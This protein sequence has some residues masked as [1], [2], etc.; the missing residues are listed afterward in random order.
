MRSYPVRHL[1]TE[2]KGAMSSEQESSEQ[3][4]GHRLR[5]EIN[6]LATH[7]RSLAQDNMRLRKD[8]ETLKTALDQAQRQLMRERLLDQIANHIRQSLDLDDILSA[9]VSDVRHFLNTDRV[10]IYRFKDDWNGVVTVESASPEVSPILFSTFE[11]PCFRKGYIERYRSGRVRTIDDIYTED[12]QTCYR[13]LLQRY[14]VRSILVVPVLIKSNS[15]LWGLLIAHQCTGP[16]QWDEIESKLLLQLSTQMGIAIHQSEL[17]AELRQLAVTDGLTQLANRR[18]FDD[19]LRDMWHQH[20]RKRTPISLVLADVD[21]FKRYNDRYGHLAGDD[22]LAA[23]GRVLSHT[24][25]RS[26]DL[27]ARYGGEEFAVVLP[28]TD[29]GEA[30]IIARRIGRE[31]ERLQLDHQG[32]PFG[33][34]TVSLGVASLPGSSEEPPGALVFA[35]DQALYR[36]KA[37]GRNCVC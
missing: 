36:A 37:K 28:Q 4:T 8:V 16:R 24:V 2:P 7:M 19:Y 3:D 33:I 34:V 18:R 30:L 6:A 1:S 12:L 9:A 21:F 11:E 31:I 25:R 35:A 27:V 17:H 29:Q 13:E 23:V 20:Q 10:L 14:Q 22:C 15:M 5:G 26:A 32:S